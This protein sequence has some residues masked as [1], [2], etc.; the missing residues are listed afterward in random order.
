M[1]RGFFGC[2]G[3][4]DWERKEEGHTADS[5]DDEE[6][7]EEEE[8]AGFDEEIPFLYGCPDP[9][10]GIME[11]VSM[12]ESKM[13]GQ[14][15]CVKAHHKVQEYVLQKGACRVCA[16]D[17]DKNNY[18]VSRF[19]SAGRYKASV[20]KGRGAELEQGRGRERSGKKRDYSLSQM[21]DAV[22]WTLEAAVEWE[23]KQ[24]AAYKRS[25]I[26][27]RVEACKKR[28]GKGCNSHTKKAMKKSMRKKAKIKPS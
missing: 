23:G 22:L 17:A 16:G 24:N 10:R 21:K 20:P 12:K 2:D 28:K 7:D 18:S 6:D 15:L 4:V 26:R 1:D 5:Q 14:V 3:S 9:K 11:D 19:H 27:N 25:S 8:S 13:E